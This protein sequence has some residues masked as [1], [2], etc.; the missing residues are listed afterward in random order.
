M[1]V[2]LALPYTGRTLAL[3][4]C[5][6]CLLAAPA[7]A[8]EPLGPHVLRP[9]EQD[10]ARRVDALLLKT[11]QGPTPP[12][13]DD[14]T[15][16][17]RVSLDLTGKL[18]GPDD[19]RAFL[20]EP[21]AGRRARLIDRLL[22][23]DAY[24]VN[25]GRY[26]RDVLTY[27]TPAS[28]NY[29]RWQLFDGW[30]TEQVRRN[31]PWGET[32]AALVTADGINDESAPVNFLTAH[33]GNPV[34]IAA[35]T[36][37]VFLGVQLQC[38]QCHNAKNEPW[39]REQFHEFVAFFGRAR[40]VQHRFLSFNGGRGTPYAIEGREDGQYTMTDLKDPQR[41][42][43][44]TPRFLTG[45]SVSL[46]ASDAE[47]RA[48]LARFLTSPKNPWFAR[49]YVNRMWT[50]LMGWGFYPG[51]ADLG[52]DVAP[53]HADVLDLLAAQWTASGYDLRWLFRT[54]AL[55]QAYQRQ[56][57]PRPSADAPAV[58][59]VC[60]SRL[61]PEQIFEALVKVLGFNE[62]DKSIPAPAPSSA[63][64]VA[65]HTG[66][67]HMVY[68]AFRVD[69]SLPHEE[70]QGTIPQALLLM[71][72]VLVNSYVVGTGKT[73]L[74]EALADK[75]LSDD[76]IVAALYERVLARQP[77]A[78][79]LATCRR[80]LARVGDRREALEDVFWSLINSTEFL[81]KR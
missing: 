46:D 43:P 56:L 8:F 2:H 45:E 34:E 37:R 18:P 38:A 73:F 25:W 71:N 80:Y 54:L 26:W 22:A 79:E 30:M 76:D 47:R 6:G 40:L 35:T 7:S 57:Q 3:A 49:A 10:V 9:C 4:L 53:R 55:T 74:A 51:L 32:V 65:R 68:Q 19:L 72:S 44:M 77:R 41:L 15:F 5:C 13:L 67:R 39:K 23:S 12:E 66:L 78:E 58:A 27:H 16:L 69:P 62:N 60:P 50:S 20:A 70:V 17:R 48:A 42:I 75:K 59:C 28:G 52:T 21:S 33:F 14:G 24:A 64:A 36:S 29:L 81:T 63:P 31:R 61:R 1:N 11:Q